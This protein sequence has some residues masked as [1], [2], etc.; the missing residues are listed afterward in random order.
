MNVLLP[1]YYKLPIERK[2]LTQV[3]VSSATAMAYD[4][5]LSPTVSFTTMDTESSLVV[6]VSDICVYPLRIGDG[7]V[8]IY[9]YFVPFKHMASCESLHLLSYLERIDSLVYKRRNPQLYLFVFP[10]SVL[11]I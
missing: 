5:T 2:T 9:G 6:P 7:G 10:N 11:P 1:N 3:T 8:S 4:K